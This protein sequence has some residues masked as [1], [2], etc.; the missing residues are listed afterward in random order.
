[1]QS[2]IF[3]QLKKNIGNFHD[4]KKVIQIF[5]VAL[6]WKSEAFFFVSRVRTPFSSYFSEIL[7]RDYPGMQTI[8]NRFTILRISVTNKES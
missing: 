5:L 8:Q 6:F 1:M 4:T 7:D 2:K 3:G